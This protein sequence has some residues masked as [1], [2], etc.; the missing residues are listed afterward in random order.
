MSVKLTDVGKFYKQVSDFKDKLSI[1]LNQYGKMDEIIELNK[2]HDK[3]IESKKI[4]AKLAIELFNQHVVIPYIDNILL[5]NDIFFFGEVNKNK[6]RIGNNDIFLIS[7]I[8]CIWDQL[9]NVTKNNI[10]KYIQVIC[11]L[12]DKVIGTQLVLNRRKEL[13]EQGLLK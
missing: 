9:D 2:Y 6:D 12:S 1:L 10:W 8:K 3:L 13:I 11:L 4:N 7:Q 5:C